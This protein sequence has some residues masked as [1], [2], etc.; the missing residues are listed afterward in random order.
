MSYFVFMVYIF[1]YTYIIIYPCLYFLIAFEV[2][3]KLK[4]NIFSVRID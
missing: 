2:L 1:L 4:I 3:K